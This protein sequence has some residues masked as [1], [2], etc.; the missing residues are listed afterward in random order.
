MAARRAL[1]R[2]GHKLSLS[3][4][5]ALSKQARR[6]L[7]DLGSAVD[8]DVAK[9]KEQLARLEPA[10]DTLDPQ[11]DPPA[12][13]VPQQVAVAFGADRPISDSVWAALSALDRYCLHKV[14][15]R[16]NLERMAKAFSEIVGASMSSPHIAPGGGVRMVSVSHKPE[17]LRRAEAESFVSMNKQAFERL[18]QREAPKGDVLATARL[19]AIMAAKKTSDVVPLCHPLPLSHV[20]VDISVEGERCRVHIK[21]TVEATARTGVEMEA[22]TAAA[23]ASLTI[24]DMLKAFDRS[25]VIGPTQLLS[26][27][28][29][30]SGDYRR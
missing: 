22:L 24:Y 15:G 29:G 27:S 10:A 20:A 23:A 1:D 16:G 4:W 8:V 30:K 13:R 12:T 14:A 9:V 26:K 3:S 2:S 21:A 28:G 5:Q 19:A 25:M 17:T 18:E 11:P 6:R 7:V